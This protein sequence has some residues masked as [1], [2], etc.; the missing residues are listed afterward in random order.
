MRQLT[1]IEPGVLEWREAPDPKIETPTDAIVRPIT[2]ALCD[3]DAAVLRGKAP[4]SGPYAFGHE[5]VAE[6]VMMGEQVAGFHQ[7]Q[8]VVVPFQISCGECE[9]CRRGLTGSCSSVPPLSMYGFGALGGPW[10]GA[11][12]DLVRVPFAQNMLVPVPAS[13]EPRTIASA[14][15]NLAD[16]WRTVGPYLGTSPGAAVLVVGGVGSIGLYAV[17]IACA[18]GAGRVEY[19]DTDPERL[20]LAKSVGATPIEGPPP[21]RLGPY[22]ITVDASAR[23]EGLACA[24]RSVEPDGVCTSIGI[25]WQETSLPL[26]EMYTTGITFKT[27]RVHSRACIPRVLDLVQSGHL[28]PERV[29]TAWVAWD[30]A[31]AALR[32]PSTKVVVLRE[33]IFGLTA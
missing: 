11:L 22:P 12:S 3:L 17:A 8:R 4:L 21:K 19:L 7:G 24:L 25:Y 26:L 31:H 28:Q 14:S 29:T 1:F 2:V 18:L 30:D 6:V 16:A 33:P 27:G 10:G 9:R 20:A 15:D 23:P 32:D 5:F 13:V